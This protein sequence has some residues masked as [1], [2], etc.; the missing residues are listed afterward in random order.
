MSVPAIISHS[1]P[2]TAQS[3]P[4]LSVLIP[5]FRDD[6][7]PLLQALSAQA[8]QSIAIWLYDDGTQDAALT[9]RV[10]QAVD[11]ANCPV[12][13]L[14][15]S[16]NKG[17]SYGRN[18]LFK[19]ANSP[20]VLFLDADMLPLTRDF[21]S[22][23]TDYIRADEADIIFGGFKVKDEPGQADTE[24][25]RVMSIASDCADAAERQALGP[26]NVA[27]SNL[28]IRKTVLADTP[29][30][31]GFTGW[32]WEDSEWA[33]RAAKTYR[34]LHIDNPA[35]HLG[36][37]TTDTLLRRFKTS[38][39]NYDR[40]TKKHPAIAKSLP[41]YRWVSRLK[42]VPAHKWLRPLLKAVVRRPIM[43]IGLRIKALK[44]WRASWYTEDMS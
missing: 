5:F 22:L 12:T 33:A 29:F 20:W 14:T 31:D 23:Y 34:L 18:H 16:A 38:G 36:L 28:C 30:D 9:Q 7:T 42:K 17:R 43:P 27:S 26:K 2:I 8:D 6:P 15:A 32:G 41:L 1:S 19:A 35:L 37:E 40:F 24:I 39:H 3:T 21:L 13:L 10:S 11:A 25:H 44:L 4:I